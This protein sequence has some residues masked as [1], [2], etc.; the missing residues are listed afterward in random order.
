MQDGQRLR[1]CIK[2][3]VKAAGVKCTQHLLELANRY[4]L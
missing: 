4:T 1:K 2:I 3:Y